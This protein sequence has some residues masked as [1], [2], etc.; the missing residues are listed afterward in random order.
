MSTLEW[1]PLTPEDL[2]QLTA[3]AIVCLKRDG[4][5]P[6]LGGA[7]ML[8]ALYLDALS[9]GGRDETGELLAVASLRREVDGTPVASFLVHPELHPQGHAQQLIDW[10]RAQ[11]GGQ[12]LRVSMETMS[13]ELEE[14]FAE[15]GLHR[16]FAE[17]VMRHRL[18]RIPQVRLPEGLVTVP[19]TPQDG[20]LFHAAY[21]LAFAERPGFP[22]TPR[23]EW[24]E[25]VLGEE[26]FRPEDSRL[27][28]DDAGGPAGFVMLVDNWVDQVG[29]VPAWRGRGLGAHLVAR[30]LTAIARGGATD[31]WLAVNVN[32]PAG[33]LYRRLGFKDRG[34]RARYADVPS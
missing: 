9:I 6:H 4:G 21:R 32:N 18:R 8:H 24:L 3:L 28:L 14:L 10:A 1:G 34:T 31:A 15:N 16:T 25:F 17:T 27:A 13:M 20:E 19:F 2:D 12:A 26:G 30:S 5:L 11:A 33:D 7:P 29:V 22:D 23:E